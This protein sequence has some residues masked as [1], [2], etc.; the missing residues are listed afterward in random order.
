[1]V[2]SSGTVKNTTIYVGDAGT[3]RNVENPSPVATTPSTSGTKV[4]ARGDYVLVENSG[5]EE[6]TTKFLPAGSTD[7]GTTSQAETARNNEFRQDFFNKAFGQGRP[8]FN[9]FAL[10]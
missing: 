8:A 7:T 3:N 4:L 6:T 2:L 1:M 5:N 9:L 10:I